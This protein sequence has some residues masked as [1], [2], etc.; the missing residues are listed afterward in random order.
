MAFPMDNHSPK[1]APNTRNHKNLTINLNT[2]PVRS[3]PYTPQTV[4]DYYTHTTQPHP[5]PLSA[6]GDSS[7][8]PHC[9]TPGPSSATFLV[10]PTA[11]YR[12]APP[13]N[14]HRI[15]GLNPHTN[16]SKT[17]PP[18]GN[19]AGADFTPLRRAA[20]AC[21]PHPPE[22]WIE[23]ETERLMQEKLPTLP[24][25]RGEEEARAY[26]KLVRRRYLDGLKRE[27]EEE[28]M[29]GWERDMERRKKMERENSG[30]DSME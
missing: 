1:D 21:M 7:T 6:I 26:R 16:T 23:A 25:E 15:E 17:Y 29:E 28:E 2:A 14:P 9:Y 12:P 5:A 8:Y 30:G 18:R 10:Q 24:E 13:C 3:L 22:A 4:D 11:T 27:L 19:G 20:P